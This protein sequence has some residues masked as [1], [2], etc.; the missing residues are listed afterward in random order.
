[1]APC[2]ENEKDQKWT[3]ALNSIFN[4]PMDCGIRHSREFASK[5]VFNDVT[6]AS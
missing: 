4:F 1:M 6:M 2:M 3:K 5:S